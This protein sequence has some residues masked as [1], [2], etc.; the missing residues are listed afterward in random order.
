M[1]FGPLAIL[2]F[3]VF[4]GYFVL[5]K[6]APSYMQWLFHASYLKYGLSGCMLAVYGY[7]RPPLALCSDDYCHYKRPEKFLEEMNLDGGNYWIDA[8]FLFVFGSALR[9][10]A[11]FVLKFRLRQF[12][13]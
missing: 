6:D 2:P 1:V 4:S 10:A 13:Q 8:L 11:Y 7:G 3:T 9:L 12:R 5:M